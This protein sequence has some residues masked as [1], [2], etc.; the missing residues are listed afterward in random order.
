MQFRRFTSQFAVA[1]GW[2]ERGYDSAAT[3]ADQ[4][5]DSHGDLHGI[6]AGNGPRRT[7]AAA[8]GEQFITLS[9]WKTTE[10]YARFRKLMVNMAAKTKMNGRD[11]YWDVESLRR[12]SPDVV[13]REL[14]WGKRIA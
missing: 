5:G 7:A 4:S 2:R 14:V 13:G 10:D 6:A 8:A 1:G 9:G 11:A 3:P 12:I